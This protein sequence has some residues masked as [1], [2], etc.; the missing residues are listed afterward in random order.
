[1]Q[2]TMAYNLAQLELIR[3]KKLSDQEIGILDAFSL[4]MQPGASGAAI[5]AARR[6]DS[7][8][9]PLTQE[10]DA[11]DYLWRTWTILLDIARSPD[12]QD[13]VHSR[14]VSVLEEVQQCAKGELGTEGV[15]TLNL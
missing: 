15:R 2:L 5:E 11:R 7:L 10:Q 14:L 1:M 6:L 8:C 3:R 13:G 12:V 4:A 9:P